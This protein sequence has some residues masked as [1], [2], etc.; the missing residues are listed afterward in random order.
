MFFLM[1]DWER[2]TEE[3]CLLDAREMEVARERDTPSS[4]RLMVVDVVGDGV[5]DVVVVDKNEAEMPL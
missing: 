2:E 4:C 1:R 3:P 5:E